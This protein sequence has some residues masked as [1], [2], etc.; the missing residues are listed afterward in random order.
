MASKV[1]TEI[2]R[3][4]QESEKIRGMFAEIAPRYDLLNHLLSGNTDIAWRKMVVESCVTSDQRAILDLACG[5]GDLALEI[6]RKAHPHCTVAGVDFTGPML[7][8]AA[9]KPGAHGVTWVEGDGLRIPFQDNSFDLVTVAFGIRN[10]ESLDGAL[11]EIL[12]VLR[13][14]GELAIL[15][16]S[17]PTNPLFRRLYH[18]YFL[19]I[20]PQ[21]GAALS[22]KS[23]Y[24]YLP[25]SVLHF[26]DRKQLAQTMIANGYRG[27]RHCA[28]TLGIAALHVGRKPK[29]TK[30]G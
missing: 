6:R 29:R 14:G 2:P 7:R 3:P 13:P 4:G 27:V 12:R 26:P 15:E 17:H 25:H 1:M 11:R 30:H 21:V 28:L 19:N 18:F 8:L 5:T 9:D 24:L 23:A 20:L 10:M 22:R 16:F